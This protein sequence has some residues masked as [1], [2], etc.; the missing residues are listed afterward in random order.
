MFL[1]FESLPAV[2]II[3]IINDDWLLLDFIRG[4]WR[5]WL[6][7]FEAWVKLTLAH[8]DFSDATDLILD[9][10]GWPSAT[11]ALLVRVWE[12][13]RLA[14]I[15]VIRAVFDIVKISLS[16]TLFEWIVILG[17]L[18][19]W[20]D[21]ESTNFADAKAWC[22]VEIVTVIVATRSV[23]LSRGRSWSHQQLCED[24]VR[25]DLRVYE[26]DESLMGLRVTVNSMVE[27]FLLDHARIV[28][29]AWEN[30][31]CCW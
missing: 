28:H 14:V 25:L 10:Y 9:A 31:V 1:L 12:R 26:W 23:T 11:R 2:V 3:D 27:W 19:A 4:S 18:F 22:P 7:L 8:V 29:L 24:L 17:W 5:W 20:W 15:S 21:H 6:L 30:L 16:F 13:L